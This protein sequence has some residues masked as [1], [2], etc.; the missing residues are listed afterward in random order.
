MTPSETGHDM[1]AEE[2][3]IMLAL[4][5]VAEQMV[6]GI[7]AR[8]ALGEI[9]ATF[10]VNEKHYPELGI[11]KGMRPIQMLMKLMEGYTTRWKPANKPPKF[12]VNVLGFTTGGKVVHV[13]AVQL[14]RPSGHV[15]FEVT[16]KANQVERDITHWCEKPAGPLQEKTDG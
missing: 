12:G 10:L 14:Y 8:R 16:P 3:A 2:T 13:Y 15:W 11:T 6:L 9:E 4:E 5:G 1:D 7:E